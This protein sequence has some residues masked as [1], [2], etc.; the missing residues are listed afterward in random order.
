MSEREGTPSEIA[1]LPD[2]R[3]GETDGIG[4][5]DNPIPLWF[6]A[7]FIGTIVFAF[8]YM[9][10]YTATGW[11]QVGQYE[12]EVAAAQ[13]HAETLKA[14]LPS[15]NPYHGDVQA[16][17]EGKQ[18][19]E[20]ICAACHKPDGSGLVGPEP[21]RSVLEVRRRRTPRSSRP[22]RRVGPAACRRWGQQL[23]TEKIWKVLAYVETLPRSDAPGVGAPGGAPTPGAPGS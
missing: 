1:E 13:A 20:Q 17:A 3:L 19:Y 6:N 4:E 5:E 10:Y 15:T 18:V 11:S 16:I 21:R 22:S 2:E 9:I 7:S 23:G 14:E 8:V 12:A